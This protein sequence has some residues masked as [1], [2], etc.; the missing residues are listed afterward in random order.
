MSLGRAT[1]IPARGLALGLLLCLCAIVTPSRAAEGD[2]VTIGSSHLP[3]LKAAVVVRV[4]NFVEWRGQTDTEA[5]LPLRLGVV[6]EGRI[7][8]ALFDHDGKSVNG[9]PLEIVAVTS[10]NEAARCHV[11]YVKEDEG[12]VLAE[13]LEMDSLPG[14]LT[15]GDSPTFN[16]DGGIIQLSLERGK[17]VFTISTRHLKDETL[18]MSSRLLSV[19]KIYDD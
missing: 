12:N 3:D 13:E 9:R 11:L 1:R 14:V 17:L 4:L 19:A 2:N 7:A 5:G 15:F 18:F 10:V 8:E 6:G 16:A